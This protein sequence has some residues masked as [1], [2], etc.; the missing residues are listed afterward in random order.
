MNNNKHDSGDPG[1]LPHSEQLLETETRLPIWTSWSVILLIFS[2]GILLTSRMYL[3]FVSVDQGRIKD[4]VL[5]GTQTLA[6][7]SETT[8]P[9]SIVREAHWALENMQQQ[10]L[11]APAVSED[12][13]EKH[14]WD[15]NLPTGDFVNIRYHPRVRFNAELGQNEM[16]TLE[17]RY[18]P[19]EPA[20]IDTDPAGP[21]PAT[22]HEESYPILLEV[23]QGQRFVDALGLNHFY[24]KSF[25]IALD[26]ARDGDVITT[27]IAYPRANDEEI[28]VI[29]SYFV[30]LYTTGQRPTT[31]EE[32][33]QRH[34]GFLSVITFGP[35][36]DYIEFLPESYQGLEVTF[37]PETAAFAEAYRDAGL[38]EALQTG[39][40]THE[41]YRSG[42]DTIH[43]YARPAYRLFQ[44]M[45]TPDRWW[46][47]GVGGIATTWICSML[48]LL[49]RNAIRLSSLVAL[50]T[51][52]LAERTERL[53]QVNLAL[54][55]S[56]ARY[57]MLADNA[58]DVIFT[59]DLAG[60]CTY[61]SPSITTFNGFAAEDCLGKPIYSHM[62]PRDEA[63]IRGF[64]QRARETP[65]QLPATT[66]FQYQTRCRNGELKTAE[67]NL[68]LLLDKQGQAAGILGV[69]RDITEARKAEAEKAAL[70]EAFRQSQK[71]EA[72]GTL[73]GGVAHDFNNLLTGIMGHAELIRTSGN[74][75]A[76]VAGSMDVIETAAQRAREL[77]AQLLGFS[78]KGPIQK[79]EVPINKM[80]LE[81]IALLKRTI[82][83][84]IVI[85][86]GLSN[87][88]LEVMGDPGQITQILLNLAVNAR[89][90]MP[91]GGR[92]T[93]ATKGV[94]IDEYF[95]L[96]H[97]EALAPGPY[98]IIT[99]TDTGTGIAREK[100]DRIFE[101]FFTDKP[102]G[103][104]TGLGLAMVY[105]VTKSH[106]G[107]V[108]VY[109]ETGVGTTFNVYLPLSPNSPKDDL[110]KTAQAPVAG[111]GT[112]L[113]VDDEP[114]LRTL[115]RTM[116]EKLG[117]QTMLAGDGEEALQVYREHGASI[118]LVLLDMIMPK[119]GGRECVNHLL[120]INPQVKVVIST[121]F[122]LESIYP[123]PTDGRHF[124]LLQKP[125]RL[126]E[127][128]EVVAAT[129]NP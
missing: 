3:Q 48:L 100:I 68:S 17:G 127:L 113:V 122:S 9:A 85:D 24:D 92:L 35:A 18:V 49:R 46:A 8:A 84:N 83:K 44:A 101:P 4:K 51:R 23:T 120:Q 31:I 73:A 121:G 43:L 50:R 14:L 129:L 102:A 115:A 25:H 114:V 22:P 26:Q 109:S 77:T 13:L 78:R 58:S 110:Q 33:R 99:V 86:A 128:S 57:K 81:T 61:I 70:Q 11:E 63:E 105:G 34:V 5:R 90:A 69:S 97:Y 37:V 111:K 112:I 67:C 28:Y 52:A 65:E 74:L 32:R 21:R 125:Y 47:L 60:V 76:E 29:S 95:T 87:T 36:R 108:T 19:F 55:D 54:G 103:K 64:L 124:G 96:T 126:Q 75:S 118:D 30:P 10:L 20:I 89:D 107:T 82:D 45:Q 53:S 42:T 79:K 6:A 27:R 39:G 1:L 59:I 56:E 7:Y 71:M 80:V 123:N 104:G 88:P 117:Y 16:Q 94:H 41:T 62:P 93:F 12:F 91:D 116:L 72:I 38:V 119:M 66:R 2:V 40:F 106:G 15:P 98:C